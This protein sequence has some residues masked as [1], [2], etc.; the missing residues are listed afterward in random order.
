M[1]EFKSYLRLRG[2][3]CLVMRARAAGPGP[4]GQNLLSQRVKLFLL[5]LWRGSLSPAATP[6]LSDSTESMI[7]HVGGKALSSQPSSTSWD[8]E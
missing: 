2:T 3:I 4:Y 5:R 7:N 1:R 6:D 8:K